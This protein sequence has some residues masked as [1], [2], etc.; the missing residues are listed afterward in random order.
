MTLERGALLNNRYHIIDVLGQGGMGAVYRA[1]D[2]N[3]GVTVAVKENL[4]LTDEYARQFRHEA[5]ILASLRHPNLPRV[6]D[7]FV[8]EGQG[9]YLV[10]DFIEGEDLRERMD[11]IGTLPENDVILIGAAICDALSYLHTRR[12]PVV[13]RDIKPGNVKIT[14]DGNIVL[15]DFGLAKLMHDKQATT[16]GAR[17]MTPGY[18]PPEQYGT[19]RT[20]PRSDIYSLGSTLYAALT[21]VIPE[22]GLARATGN[23]ELTPL[24]KID[25]KISKRLAS[26]IEKSLSLRSDDRFQSAEEFKQALLDAN[27]TTRSLKRQ[28]S[29]SPAPPEELSSIPIAEPPSPLGIGQGF[30][31]PASPPRSRPI[32]R[33]RNNSGCVLLLVTL[34]LVLGG[35]AAAIYTYRPDLAHS[36]LAMFVT[37]TPTSTPG[38]SPTAQTISVAETTTPSSPT[39]TVAPPPLPSPTETAA[40]YPAPTAAPTPTPV[41]GGYGQLAFVSDR[42]G[43]PQIWMMDADGTNLRQ[44]TSVPSGACQPNWSPDGNQLVFISPCHGKSELYPGASLFTINVD[45]SNLQPLPLAPEGDFDPTWSSDGKKIAFTSLRSGK[46]Q[47]YA[48]GPG[49]QSG[50]AGFQQRLRRCPAFLVS[51][52]HAIGLHPLPHGRSGV[53]D[54]RY[55]QAPVPILVQRRFERRLPRVDARRPGH[56]LYSN[57]QDRFRPLADGD[58]LRRPRQP[59]WQGVPHPGQLLSDRRPRGLAQRFTGRILDRLRKLARRHEPRYLHHVDHRGEPHPPDHRPGLGLQPRLAADVE[60]VT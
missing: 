48:L 41:G 24:R 15:V 13:H 30:E 55:R 21:G 14:P 1:Q 36:V 16:T 37:S 56:P 50:A 27:H 54:G 23:A 19:A 40:P 12:P 59:K 53:G 60:E 32:R 2:E 46:A 44:I 10:M 49:H 33:T 5:S 52:R 31:E 7:H 42:T 18:S 6:G 38:V 45:G 4:F 9:Q 51:H 28:Q 29:V 58:A 25:P 20:D 11:R 22:D 35:G 39:K 17:A 47:I 8:I 34:L 26:A 3:L 57:Y 43:V